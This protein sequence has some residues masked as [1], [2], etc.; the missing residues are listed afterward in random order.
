MMNYHTYTISI[1]CLY[2]EEAGSERNILIDINLIHVI[3]ESR[4]I[5]IPHNVNCHLNRGEFS[6]EAII[7][8]QDTKN[9]TQ[10]LVVVLLEALCY[11]QSTCCGADVEEVAHVQRYGVLGV[12]GVRYSTI[13]ALK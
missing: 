1:W 4:T 8:C 5:P 11:R 9:I 10:G 3:G 2:L 7:C 13:I 6:W 12:D